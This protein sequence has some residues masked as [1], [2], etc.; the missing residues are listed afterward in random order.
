MTSSLLLQSIGISLVESMI[1]Q[2]I[3]GIDDRLWILV[4]AQRELR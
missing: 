2:D 1:G 3:G 4:L